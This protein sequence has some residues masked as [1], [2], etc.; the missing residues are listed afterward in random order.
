MGKAAADTR[1]GS[2][3]SVKISYSEGMKCRGMSFE[4]WTHETEAFKETEMRKSAQSYS[5]QQHELDQKQTA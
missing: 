5:D 3:V 1:S 2:K 4:V